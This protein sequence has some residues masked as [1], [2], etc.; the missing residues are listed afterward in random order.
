ML[1][2]SSTHRGP[3]YVR[4]WLPSLAH[5]CFI[6]DPRT[7]RVLCE[8]N[9]KNQKMVSV[10]CTPSCQSFVYDTDSC[11]CPVSRIDWV[12]TARNGHIPSQ[13][14]CPHD[15]REE[16]L[17]RAV[18]FLNKPLLPII[19][20]ILQSY[21]SRT[22][23]LGCK[24]LHIDPAGFPI[25]NTKWICMFSKTLILLPC[26]L[27]SLELEQ[28]KRTSAVPFRDCLSSR[29]LKFRKPGT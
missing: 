8:P 11:P 9:E 4:A 5:Y 17:L 10:S 2:G 6:S 1:V 16:G 29:R 12:Q 27:C 15:P 28:I 14:F 18:P 26:L 13:G 7:E 3:D 22:S 23:P 20:V 21:E 24:L 19:V 25:A